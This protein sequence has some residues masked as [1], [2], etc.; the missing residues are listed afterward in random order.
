MGFKGT[1]KLVSKQNTVKFTIDQL[2]NALNVNKI[3]V[4]VCYL[5]YL[6]E[7]IVQKVQFTP[8]LQKKA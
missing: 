5:A 6:V 1:K 3:G 4:D 7:E 2:K 8:T